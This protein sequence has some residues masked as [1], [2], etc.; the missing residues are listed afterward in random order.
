[1]TSLA[2]HAYLAK[3]MAYECEKL[4][5]QTV[6]PTVVMSKGSITVEPFQLI[7]KGSCEGLDLW[8]KNLKIN[9]VTEAFND[10]AGEG[11]LVYPVSI[12]RAT[13]KRCHF[14]RWPSTVQTEY[15]RAIT[16]GTL[17]LRISGSM[18][19][20]VIKFPWTEVRTYGR[21]ALFD[22]DKIVDLESLAKA[23]QNF[24][25]QW[26]NLPADIEAA[27][28]V[29]DRMGVG[30]PS[31]MTAKDLKESCIERVTGLPQSLL[32]LH[33]K[34]AV[35]IS[36]VDS[37]KQLLYPEPDPPPVGPGVNPNTPKRDGTIP[38][39]NMEKETR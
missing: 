28:A 14:D 37:L 19:N 36:P 4:E 2:I 39:K 17:P 30:L 3:L 18:A 27:A 33:S 6:E 22:M 11:V 13:R 31:T 9:L 16:Q 12:P 1:M 20:P 24:L 29:A 21:R 25:K 32:K 26:G 7:G 34:S 23:R 8:V 35:M 38:K 5:F 15:V 10:D